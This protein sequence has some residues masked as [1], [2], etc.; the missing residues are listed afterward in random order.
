M[1]LPRSGPKR[2]DYDKAQNAWFMLKDG[3]EW[4]LRD[5]LNR[6]L[7]QIFG[8]EIKVNLGER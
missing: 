7:S 3:E 1:Q 6:E 8:K 4:N 5:L 2:F